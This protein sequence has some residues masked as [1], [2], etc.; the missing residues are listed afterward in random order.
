MKKL[1]TFIIAVGLTGTMHAQE[2]PEMI[3]IEGGT[4][5]MGNSWGGDRQDELPVHSTTLS[6]FY[7]AKTETTVLQ[8]KAF[9]KATGKELPPAPSQGWNDDEP[10]ASINWHEA[11]EYTEWLSLKTRKKYRIPTE[12][13]WEFAARGG[14]MSAGTI[15]S[16]SGDVDVVSWYNQNSD[17]QTHAVAKKK[18]NE[19]GLY[20]MTGNVWE[21]TN[22]VHGL[23]DSANAVNPKGAAQGNKVVFRGGGFMEPPPY[24]R[25]TMRGQAPKREYVFRDLGLR[26][27]CDGL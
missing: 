15:Y 18:A 8:W 16:G 5:K 26:V 25:V 9:C 1:A 14:N 20:D 4:F 12:A 24:I 23:Y 10:I 6:T 11:T 22:D 27:V 13:E 17:K 2:F 3:K 7:I 19:L 21:W